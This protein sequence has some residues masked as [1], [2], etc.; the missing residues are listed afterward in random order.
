[1]LKTVAVLD[2][3]KG[4]ICM[5]DKRTATVSIVESFRSKH[6]LKESELKHEIVNHSVKE[7]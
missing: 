3:Q 6:R 2:L 5:S 4:D 7:G 1:M